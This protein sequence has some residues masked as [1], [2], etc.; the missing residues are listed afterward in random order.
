MQGRY[1]IAI[2]GGGLAGSLIALALAARRPNLSVVLIEAGQRIGGNHVWSFFATDI[3]DA[4]RDLVEPMF[5]AQWN[6]GYD[7]R[8]P[9]LTRT[10]ATPYR[11]ITSEN[12]DAAVR[13]ALPAD[14][15]ITG[16]PVAAVDATSVTLEDGTRIAATGVIDARG[17]SPDLLRHFSGG[18]QKFVGVMLECDEPHGMDRPIVMDATVPQLDGYRFVYS[19]PFG[20]RSVFVEDTYY[21]DTP[22]L[23]HEALL[24]RAH[25]YAERQGWQ[26]PTSARIESGVLPV[27]TDG[28]FDAFWE[29]TDNRTGRAGV[30]AGLFQPLTSYSLPDAVRFASAVAALPA[31]DSAALAAF[32]RDYAESHWR[33]GNFY[34]LLARMLFGASDPADRYKVLQRFYGLDEALV[35]RFYAGR[36]THADKLRVLAGK[37]PVP[38]MRAV[39]VLAGFGAPPP[40]A[41]EGPE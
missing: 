37:P 13:D 4:D 26:A 27:V 22:D 41:P 14:A 12:L 10:L 33:R 2:A 23:D 16:Q 9:A 7:V 17:L 8:F 21:S 32:S 38:L 3:A 24:A 40:L 35:E 31:L 36:S 18:W 1:D 19:L 15:V 28:D 25:D 34:R 20:P 11:S 30:R 29:E 6:A 39:K 5:A